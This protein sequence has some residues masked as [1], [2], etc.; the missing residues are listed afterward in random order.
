MFTSLYRIINGKHYFVKVSKI[1]DTQRPQLISKECWV[2]FREKSGPAAPV[3]QPNPNPIRA[4]EAVFVVLSLFK[5]KHIA[6]L[7]AY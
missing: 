1:F 4:K 3:S 6:Q 7:W 2:D 5:D